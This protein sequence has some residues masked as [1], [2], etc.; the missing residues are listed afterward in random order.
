MLV[1]I[2]RNIVECKVICFVRLSIADFVLIETL[3]N[4]KSFTIMGYFI[5]LSINRNIVECKAV[6]VD[7]FIWY[8]IAVLI[9]T[10]W[11]VKYV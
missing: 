8:S 3:W 7:A 4:V 10:L 11:N 2:N 5:T 9:E 1:S 6:L